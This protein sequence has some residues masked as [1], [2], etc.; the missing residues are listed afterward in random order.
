MTTVLDKHT[1]LRPEG[2]L[3]IVVWPEVGP[4]RTNEGFAQIVLRSF[5]KFRQW[6]SIVNN[7]TWHAVN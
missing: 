7:T 1:L 2:K 3:V 5:Q 4:A 6:C